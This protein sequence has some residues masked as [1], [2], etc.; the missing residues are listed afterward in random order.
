M[1]GLGLPT[2]AG[3][4]E[5]FQAALSNT[6]VILG[7]IST[8]G[9]GATLTELALGTFATE[10]IIVL[11]GIGAAGYVGASIGSMAVASGRVLGCG[12]RLA[13]MLAFS[14]QYNLKF[15][16]Y[17][18]FYRLHPEIFDISATNRSAFGSRLRANPSLFDY[19]A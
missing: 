9:K 6:G 15:E 10:K 16:G 8:S 5:S 19:A 1:D 7:A 2:P 14:I 13:D 12:S 17:A 3:L 11:S 4:Y 18:T